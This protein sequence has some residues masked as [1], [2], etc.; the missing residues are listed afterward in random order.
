M[1]YEFLQG[2]YLHVKWLLFIRN[3]WYSLFFSCRHVHRCINTRRGRKKKGKLLSHQGKASSLLNKKSRLQSAS[4][5]HLWYLLFLANLHVMN[6]CSQSLLC[7]MIA[8]KSWWLHQI[9]PFEEKKRIIA[10]QRC[11]ELSE[12]GQLFYVWLGVLKS[13]LGERVENE[14]GNS[15]KPSSTSKCHRH[16]IVR[17]RSK[18]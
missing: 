13:I 8:F 2:A 15:R 9:N 6:S 11:N 16:L 18:P 17:N 12:A 7:N 10:L 1:I 14:R 3:A 5:G 4:P